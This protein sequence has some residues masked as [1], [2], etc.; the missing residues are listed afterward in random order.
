MISRCRT[1]RSRTKSL[2]TR[3]RSPLPDSL[4]QAGEGTVRCGTKPGR[5][6]ARTAFSSFGARY[7]ARVGERESR[8]H[9][10]IRRP[11]LLGEKCS[12]CVLF[13]GPVPGPFF[14]SEVVRERGIARGWT[15]T[16]FAIFLRFP[17]RLPPGKL[18]PFGSSA[19]CF[20]TL[21]LQ[22][23]SALEAGCRSVRERGFAQAFAPRPVGALHVRTTPRC[24]LRNPPQRST[25]KPKRRL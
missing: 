5:Q 20:F 23:G 7:A 19:G 18:T 15:W 21:F 22:D 9:G 11:L 4:P 10:L 3:S 8:R 16:A 2:P 6:P 12:R 24:R 13:G 1:C 14:A 17:V 25:E